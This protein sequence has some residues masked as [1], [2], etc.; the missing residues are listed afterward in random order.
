MKTTLKRG[1]GRGHE[2]NGNGKM[3]LP[4]GPLA[5]ITVYRQPEPPKRSRRSLALA[6]LGWTLTVIVVCATGVAGGAYLWVHETVADVA[7]K[8]VD[9]KATAKKLD[10]PVAGQ[11]ATA[12]V[13]GYDRRAD[14]AKNAPSRSDTLML[15]RANPK[16][17]TIS[18]LSFPR[19]LRAE[20]VCPG[21]STYVSKIN[22]AYA[23]CGSRGTLD[24]V[25]K[26]TG[27]AG[28]LPHHRQLP[29]LHT[30]RRQA[31]RDL[32]G[33]RPAL[34]QRPQRP[35]RVRDD[36]PAAGLPEAERLPGARL[37]PLPAH[38]QRPLPQRAPA[39]LRARLQGSGPLELLAHQAAEGDQ[40]AHAQHRGRPGRR[41]RRERQDGAL[42][43]RARLLTAA[44]PRLPVAD[45][46]PRGVRRPDDVVQ[47]HRCRHAR[48]GESGRRVPAEGNCRRAR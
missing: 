5:P 28:Q 25:R 40:G 18:L 32:D 41:P 37:R 46:G 12:L 14:E 34:L 27:D 29:G 36:Q 15:I 20:I 4:P 31:R 38:G 35:D 2:I 26:L 17:E 48:V 9:V 23:D 45:R 44:G 16:N 30:G 43:R 7:P 21:R 3:Q 8:S 6:I 1:V 39:D 13:I 42:V 11:P 47:Q 24:T 22:A 33:R 19:D 10:L